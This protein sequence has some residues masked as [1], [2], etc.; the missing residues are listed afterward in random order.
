MN[1]PPAGLWRGTQG[2]FP[3]AIVWNGFM[4][5]FTPFMLTAI[6]NGKGA[7]QAA[8]IV[9]HSCRCFGSWALAFCWVG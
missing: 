1:V 6:F 7:D 9:P 8:W 3:F 2:L 5:V 4:A